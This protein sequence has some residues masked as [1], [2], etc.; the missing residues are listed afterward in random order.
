MFSSRNR[1]VENRCSRCRTSVAD[2]ARVAASTAEAQASVAFDVAE[3]G[4]RLLAGELR[5]TGST[6]PALPRRMLAYLAP[7]SAHLTERLASLHTSCSAVRAGVVE[8]DFDGPLAQH[9]P[10]DHWCRAWPRQGGDVRTFTEATRIH[11]PGERQAHRSE[12][13]RMTV[14]A[15]RRARG[16][17]H[18]PYHGC[19][20]Y[21]ATSLSSTVLMDEPRVVRHSTSFRVDLVPEGRFLVRERQAGIAG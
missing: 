13:P 20:C 15:G 19:A 11:T 1:R 12:A 14:V 9:V 18:K 6:R 7:L 5:V 8:L 10:R 16:Q 21:K 3:E 2:P 17:L 4:P